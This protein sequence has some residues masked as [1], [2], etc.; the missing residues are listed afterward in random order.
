MKM[1]CTEIEKAWDRVVCR[2]VDCLCFSRNWKQWR[3]SVVW[4]EVGYYDDEY[5]NN[6]VSVS[7]SLVVK[8][9]WFCN[10]ETVNLILHDCDISELSDKN[11]HPEGSEAQLAAQ[12]CVS[13]FYDDI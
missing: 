2:N 7:R 4:W 6:S 9:I 8:Y 10:S 5:V 11:K 12:L 13:I 1:T 3:R